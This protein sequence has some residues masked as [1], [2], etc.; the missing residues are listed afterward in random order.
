M[1]KSSNFSAAARARINEIARRIQ[2]QMDKLGYSQEKLSASC[3][4]IAGEMYSEAEQPK[5]RRDRIAKILMNLRRTPKSSIAVTISDAELSVLARALKCSVEWLS[6]RGLEKEPVIWNVLA[7]P[8]RSAH[9]LHLLEEY[10]NRAGESTVWSK[11]LLCSFTTEEFMVAFHRAH[12]GEMNTAGMTKDPQDLVGFFNRTGRVRRKRVLKPERSFSFTSMIYESELRRV[13][14]GEGVYKSIPKSTRKAT[15]A[16][17]SAVLM[18]PSLKMN[19]VIVDEARV[20]RPKVAWRDYETVGVMG[21]LFSIWNYHSESIGWTENP[22]YVRHQRELM[23]EMK[24]HAV[25]KDTEETISY[26]RQMIGL[27]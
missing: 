16:H 5:L 7:E 9:L 26:I 11:Y 17:I 19:L 25:C 15:L 10:E 13:V 21:D 4:V 27:L 1:P 6:A 24:T 14:A 23:D 8:E 18:N 12:F 3:G 22:S 2:S 20:H